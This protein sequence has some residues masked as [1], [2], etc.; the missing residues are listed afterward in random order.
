MG[1]WIFLNAEI[2]NAT[3][4]LSFLG[5]TLNQEERGLLLRR[6]LVGKVI[7]DRLIEH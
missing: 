4:K 2:K 6:F 5:G 1:I 7:F 3:P